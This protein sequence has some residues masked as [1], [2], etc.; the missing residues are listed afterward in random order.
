MSE[1][2]LKEERINF[3]DTEVILGNQKILFSEI[4]SIYIGEQNPAKDRAFVFIALGIVLIVFTTRWFLAGGVLAVLAGIVTFFDSRR[5][6]TVIIKKAGKEIPASAS[7]N[8][9]KAKT[10]LA[11]LKEKSKA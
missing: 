4:E 9:K 6:Y 2:L 10:I 1:E 7:Y 8:L 3:S 5:K 11:Y